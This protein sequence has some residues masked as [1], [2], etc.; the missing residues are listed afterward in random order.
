MFGDMRL[1]LVLVLTLASF[2][3][4]VVTFLQVGITKNSPDPQNPLN[5]AARQWSRRVVTLL[6]TTAGFA[7]LT[8]RANRSA[9]AEILR[10]SRD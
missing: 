8:V 2:L 4:L 1:K 6:A 9:R 3:A 10:S 7:V 5:V